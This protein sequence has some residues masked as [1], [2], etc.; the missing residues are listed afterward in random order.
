MKSTALVGPL[1][2]VLVA[3]LFIAAPFASQAPG[4][5]PEKWWQSELYTKE[6]NLST[7]QSRD[8]EE[9]FQRALP[10]LRERK[11]QF[12]EAEALFERLAS[13]GDKKAAADQI[14]RLTGAR[15]ELSNVHYLMLLDMRYV[16]KPEQWTKFEKMQ[17]QQQQQAPYDNR[18]APDKAK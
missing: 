12:D 1:A 14:P 2:A 9:I 10:S 15:R 7:T 5:K 13:K 16:L 17:Q 18:G 4:Q 8:L 6:L 3:L 11:R